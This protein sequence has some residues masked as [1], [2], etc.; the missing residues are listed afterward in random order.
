MTSIK[1]DRRKI[2]GLAAGF[3]SSSFLMPFEIAIADGLNDWLTTPIPGSAGRRNPD[4]SGTLPT[5]TFNMLWALFRRIGKVWELGQFTTIDRSTLQNMLALKTVELPS[6][7]SEYRAG[8]EVIQTAIDALDS[9]ADAFDLLIGGEFRAADLGRT[10]LGR[11][12][13][14]VISELVTFQVSHGG[15]RRFGYKN[16][17]GH[18]GGQFT[19]PANP[20]YRAAN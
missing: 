1:L 7:F 9:R 8:A 6:Y 19:D 13:R 10:R 12:R 3:A 5:D 17:R 2:I 11:L 20:P 4:R 14:H 18:M 15:F 16:Y